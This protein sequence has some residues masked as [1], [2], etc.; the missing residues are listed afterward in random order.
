M[1]LN[2]TETGWND[3]LYWENQDKKTLKQINKLIADISRSGYDGIGK[4]ILTCAN[5]C[6]NEYNKTEGYQCF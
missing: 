3:Y 6:A 2:F 5:L 1:K 4:Y